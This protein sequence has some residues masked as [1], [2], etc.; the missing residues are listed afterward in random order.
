MNLIVER[1]DSKSNPSPLIT[2]GI[3]ISSEGML[4]VYLASASEHFINDI[5]SRLIQNPQLPNHDAVKILHARAV[6]TVNDLKDMLIKL[7]DF[8]ERR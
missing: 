3:R 2:Y 8:N 7:D 1:F 5:F 6:Q 4:P